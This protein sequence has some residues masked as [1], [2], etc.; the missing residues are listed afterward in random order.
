MFGKIFSRFL[1]EIFFHCPFLYAGLSSLSLAMFEALRG[2][3]DAVAPESGNLGGAANNNRDSGGNGGN[4]NGDS[5]GGSGAGGQPDFE[6]LMQSYRMGDP[7]TVAMVH[8]ANNGVKPQKREDF[9]RLHAKMEMEKDTELVKRLAGTVLLKS[10][11]IDTQVSELPG[12][13]R[14]RSKQMEYIGKLLELNREA[15]EELEK[16]YLTAQQRRDVVRKRVRENTCA[17]LGIVEDTD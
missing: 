17:A 2:L 12:M 13:N 5:G 7:T 16:A 10:A 8:R 1:T 9:I 6:E 3:R 14:T 15:S 4:D 11:D